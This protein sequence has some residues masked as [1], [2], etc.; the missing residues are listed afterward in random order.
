MIG[1]DITAALPTL[2]AHAR[3]LMVEGW[4]CVRPVGHTDPDPVTGAVSPIFSEIR[5]AGPARII[6]PDAPRTVEAGTLTVQ[7]TGAVVCIPHDDPAPIREGDVFECVSSDRPNRV[8]LRLVVRGEA[9]RT[10]IVQRKFSCEE[11][12]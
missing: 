12:S 6:R 8:G 11:V 2:R 1:A 4:R 10:H 9:D 3:S 5:T 7:A